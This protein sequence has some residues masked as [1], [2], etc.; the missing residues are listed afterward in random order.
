MKKVSIIVPAYNAENYIDKCLNSLINQTMK[1]IEIIVINDG[2]T[3]KTLS[4]LNKYKDKIILINQNNKGIGASRNIG[5]GKSNGEYIV[6][7]DSDDFV[8]DNMCEEC[9]QYAKNN[10]LDLLIF[11]YLEI[12][13]EDNTTRNNDF[14]EDF[15]ITNIKENKELLTKINTSPWN[16]L[17]KREF[18][19]KSKV[20]FP[21]NVKYEDF[22]F[23]ELVLEKAKT[24]GYLKDRYYNYLIRK[25]SET[26][27]IDKKVYD[28]FK[29]LDIINSHYKP[30]KIYN[31]EIE[32]LNVIRVLTYTISQRQQ[33]DRKFRNKFIDD[34]FNYLNSNF[35]DWKNNKYY[36]KRNILKRIIEKSKTISKI[37][38]ELYNLLKNK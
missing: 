19:I 27:T 36:N 9:Y 29:V 20:R 38:C 21:E 31:D 37:Y 33:K 24:I 5:I 12:N 3:D 2:S 18:L 1:D 25:K 6:F 35:S 13:E 34:G 10:N 4:I 11:N 32:Y 15:G 8:N 14:I 23:V 17:Y 26:T 16:K 28:I 7:V 30:L 22:P